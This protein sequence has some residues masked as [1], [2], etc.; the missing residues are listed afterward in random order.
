M[1]MILHHPVWFMAQRT[2]WNTLQRST[3]SGPRHSALLP[4]C[5]RDALATMVL[6][7]FSTCMKRQGRGEP[8]HCLVTA[9]GPRAA[10]RH[11]HPFGARYR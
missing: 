1:L 11:V 7:N 4:T 2:A 3:P 8:K 10:I 9:C 5:S 6:P